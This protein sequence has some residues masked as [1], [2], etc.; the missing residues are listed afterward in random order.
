MPTY[1]ETDDPIDHMVDFQAKMM[2][3]WVEDPM[4]FRAFFST[5]EG[6]SATLVLVIATLIYQLL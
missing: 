3:T 6:C 2:V 5:L 1:D 4:Y